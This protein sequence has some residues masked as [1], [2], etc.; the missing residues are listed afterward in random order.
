MRQRRPIHHFYFALV[1]A[2]ALCIGGCHKEE[3]PEIDGPSTQKEVTYTHIVYM[4]GENRLSRYVDTDLN[5]MTCALETM[6]EHSRVVVFVDDA[7]SSRILMGTSASGRLE[8]TWTYDR[9]ICST[10]SADMER[11]LSDIEQAYPSQ[12]Y[13]LTL[14]SHG[15]GWVFN[16]PADTKA[17]TRAVTP[18]NSF[19]VDNGK[20]SGTTDT[21]AK[22][23]I[24]T[25]AHVLGHH[26]HYDV[27]MMDACF[28]Q[29]VEVAYEL[30]DVADYIIGSAAEIPGDGAPYQYVLPLMSHT[31]VDAQAVAYA[32]ADYYVN[33]EGCRQYDGVVLS[34]VVTQKLQAL[35]QASREL[36]GKVFAE[37][38]TSF[39]SGVQRYN[40][41]AVSDTYA[42]YYDMASLLC[43]QVGH[44]LDSLDYAVWH[45][46]LEEA[47]P[48]H[49]VS[50]RWYSCMGSMHYERL[51]DETNSVGLSM[52]SPNAI[53]D[54][55]GW[56]DLYH[57]LGWYHA[58][59]LDQTGW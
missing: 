37:R 24:P 2:S 44:T 56:V 40:P 42:E 31:P 10:D 49:H 4:A 39:L 41:A 18:R 16:T 21:G 7:T 34:L 58:A 26:K 19:G 5:E 47:L 55:S 1:L 50:S 35:A 32:Y 20:R 3:H 29:C 59:G 48:Y 8:T 13:T 36:Y 38:S 9:N 52:F 6:D 22:M 17:Q 46:A 27:L 11:V 43:H 53:H 25:L 57:R 30:K 23:N 28:M 15:S 51:Q 12:H 14:W 45:E 54:E 33:G